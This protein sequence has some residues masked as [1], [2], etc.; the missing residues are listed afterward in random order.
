MGGERE[1]QLDG[2]AMAVWQEEH[3]KEGEAVVLIS[4]HEYGAACDVEL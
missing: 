4:C 2:G 3:Q 1:M